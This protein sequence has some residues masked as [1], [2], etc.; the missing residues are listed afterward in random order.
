VT[1]PEQTSG[2]ETAGPLNDELSEL[3]SETQVDESQNQEKTDV[4]LRQ[5]GERVEQRTVEENNVVEL[6]FDDSNEV[7][8]IILSRCNES[9]LPRIPCR[10]K[11]DMV[12]LYVPRSGGVTKIVEVLSVK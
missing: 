1:D 7:Q 9:S 6:D 12:R 5:Q 4:V 11:E 10:E 8:E 2:T 3:T